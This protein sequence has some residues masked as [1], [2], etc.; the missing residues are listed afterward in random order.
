L[1]LALFLA[2]VLVSC[3]L[4]ERT[5]FMLCTALVV[6]SSLRLAVPDHLVEVTALHCAVFAGLTIALGITA[7]RELASPLRFR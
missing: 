4:V 5:L 6:D 3:G 1:G 2:T 7:Y